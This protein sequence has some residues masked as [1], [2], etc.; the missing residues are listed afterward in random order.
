MSRDLFLGDL[1]IRFYELENNISGICTHCHI[2]SCPRASSRR[3]L[4][5]SAAAFLLRSLRF[6]HALC[7][8]FEGLLGFGM[9]FS[10]NTISEGAFGNG[11]II[12]RQH[13]YGC[14]HLRA[15]MQQL[16]QVV[17]SWQNMGS[18]FP[19]ADHHK[20]YMLCLLAATPKMVRN[21]LDQN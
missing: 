1:L 17:G 7:A 13:S 3:R 4:H 10:A 9:L 18:R 20:S 5:A 11:I 14:Q 2:A 6:L 16:L 12:L 15:K 19:H 21:F 8:S